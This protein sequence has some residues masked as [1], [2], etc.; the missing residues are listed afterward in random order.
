LAKALGTP[1][2]ELLVPKLL[3]V[4]L[5]CLDALIV[6]EDVGSN[7]TGAPL[8]GVEPNSKRMR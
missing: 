4:G 7:P 2:G 3:I 6:L 5:L 8:K 1:P